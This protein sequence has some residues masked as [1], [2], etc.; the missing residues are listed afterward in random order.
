MAVGRAIATGRPAES[1][2]E[3]PKAHNMPR[4]EP[5]F[6]QEVALFRQE[7]AAAR[8]SQWLGTVLLAP[9]ISQ[10]LLTGFATLAMAG[11]VSLLFFADY[12]RKERVNGWLVPEQ[13]VVR[14]IAPQPGVIAQLH[15]RDG[16]QVSKGAPLV[17]LSAEIQSEAL[18]STQNEIVQRLKTRRESLISQRELQKHLLREETTGLLGRIAALRSEHDQLVEEARIQRHHASLAE[19]A[20]ARL[21]PLLGAGLITAT[22]LEAAEGNRLDQARKLR[23]LERQQTTVER[24]RLA[25]E[26][27]RDAL[28]LKSEGKLSDLDRNIA[29]L[30]QELAIAEARRQIVVSA[31]QAGVVTALRAEHGSSVST[32]IP[33]LNIVPAGSELTAQL[34]V[35]SGAIGFI[36]IGQEVRLRYRAFPYQKFGHYAGRVAHVSRAAVS[37]HEMGTQLAGLTTLLRGDEP[38]YLVTVRLARQ[39]VTAYA[40]AVPLQPGMQLQ[41]DVEIE[42]RRLIEWVFDPL[43]TVTGRRA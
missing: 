10:G 14:V 36:R 5:P 22:R 27:E 11:L 31:A 43:Y 17:T 37:P 29:T 15:V 32:T 9:T 30:E 33:L 16:E 7:V 20:A 35:P 38:V 39:T 41:A 26:A 4:E 25:L 19:E 1:P 23:S 28:P 12:T 6:L 40:E 3:S 13:G 34:F 24:E 8:Q 42:T 21:R 18:G 2:P